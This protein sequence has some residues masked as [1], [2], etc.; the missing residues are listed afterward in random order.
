[1]K[2]P[3]GQIRAIGASIPVTIGDM[4][5]MLVSGPFRL[6]YLVFNTLFGLLSQARQTECFG[7]VG[8]VLGPDGVF[9][10]EC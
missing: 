3:D 4:A 1:L 9:V 8:R 2:A 5:D 10:I 6:V 7:N